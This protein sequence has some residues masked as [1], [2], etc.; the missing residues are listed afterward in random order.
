MTAI[1]LAPHLM[2]HALARN[3]ALILVRGILAVVFGAYALVWPRLTLLVLVVVFGI[4]MFAD[5]VVAVAA[6]LQGSERAPRWWLAVTGLAGIALG[7]TSFLWPA[8]T[9]FSLLLLVAAWA[10]V[11]GAVQLAGAIWLRKEIEGE[12]LL[13][14]G[15]ALSVLFGVSILLWPGAGALALALSIGGYA[16]VYGLL[17]I[18]FAIRLRRHA[19][20]T[21]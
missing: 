17:L 15:G 5:G 8:V 21:W 3:W 4:Y 1:S 6:A 13:V 7:C 20:S 11:I 10:I 19:M 9:G 2:L 16:I 14:A 18:G 12:W